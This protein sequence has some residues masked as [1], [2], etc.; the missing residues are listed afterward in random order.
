[1]LGLLVV[2]A[3]GGFDYDL[4]LLFWELMWVNNVGLIFTC[5]CNLRVLRH[6]A[7][8]ADCLVGWL[9]VLVFGC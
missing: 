7:C 5:V 4:I 1:M 2:S 3:G 9:L 6:L 8:V